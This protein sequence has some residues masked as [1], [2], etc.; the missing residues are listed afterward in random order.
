MT[1][2]KL[3]TYKNDR[4]NE[5]G[6]TNLI[7]TE[8]RKD[9]NFKFRSREITYADCAGQQIGPDNTSVQQKWQNVEIAR[10]EA[11]PRRCTN[12]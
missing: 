12:Q 8:Q 9:R 7:G 10:E 6:R 4:T 11:I 2:K 5:K 1:E 3:D